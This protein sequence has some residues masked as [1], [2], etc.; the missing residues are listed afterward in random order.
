MPSLS[1]GSVASQTSHRLSSVI[2]WVC[3]AICERTHGWQK[4]AHSTSSKEAIFKSMGQHLLGM[5]KRLRV[6][7]RSKIYWQSYNWEQA[8][9]AAPGRR[10]R[11]RIIMYRFFD[12][13]RATSRRLNLPFL[14]S[15]FAILTPSMRILT[16]AR[17]AALFKFVQFLVVFQWCAAVTQSSHD[18]VLRLRAG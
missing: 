7:A 8:P 3:V 1:P 6:C 2:A 4:H 11:W 17:A 5:S 18:S 10:S 9:C 15:P 16:N 13:G 14:V 12:L